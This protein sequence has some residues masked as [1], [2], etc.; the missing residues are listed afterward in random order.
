MG[1][2]GATGLIVGES[3]FGVVNAGIIAASQG[4]SPLEIFE[5]SI[6][7]TIVGIVLFVAGIAFIYSRTAKAAK[8]LPIT[9]PADAAAA[10]RAG[11]YDSSR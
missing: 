6:W 1:T 5:E 3:L 11:S 2:L 7:T 9:A 10:K 4:E 8:D